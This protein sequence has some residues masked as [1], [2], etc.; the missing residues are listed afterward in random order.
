[1]VD[2]LIQLEWRYRNISVEIYVVASER[3]G[4]E[5]L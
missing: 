1:M 3:A 4:V 5:F 2:A